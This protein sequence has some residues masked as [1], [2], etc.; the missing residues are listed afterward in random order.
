MKVNFVDLRK[1]YETIKLDV[2]RAILDAVARTDYIL[3]S[4]V[5]VFEQE[6]ASFCNSKHCVGVDSGTSALH[7]ALRA[8][9]I[10]RGDEVITTP[11]TFIATAFAISYSGARPVFVDC[12]EKSFNIDVSKIEQ[13][14]TSKTKA[15]I[16]VHLY[17]QPA[18]M[19]EISEIAE[20]HGLKIIEDACQ[21]HGA[22]YSGKRVPYT[23]IGCFSFYPGKNLGA[24]GDGGAVVTGSEELAET[25]RALRHYGSRVK[26]HHDFI[27]FNNRLD[28][29][30]AAVLRVKLKHLEKWNEARRKNAKLYTELLQGSGV[31]VPEELP[32]RK[33]VY[34]LYVIR[35]QK[36]QE[37][38]DF[39]GKTDIA[40]GIHY[41]VPI[42]LQKAYSEFGYSKG[43]FPISEKIS[44][45][46]LSLPMHPDLTEE[47]IIETSEVVR[48]VA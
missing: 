8:L 47:D 27:G 17:G 23:D 18:E 30:Q 46:I 14:I 34:H 40:S 10:G 4:E 3:G 7:L 12:D 31:A 33:H 35:T 45:E 26:Q 1:Q 20:K 16:P 19:K 39:L 42:H 13:T 32:N 29:V 25:L 11:N 2:D 36:R 24:Y 43:S 6:F 37:L 21:A 44:G 38:M 15:I 22:E 28:N 9:G 41:Q 5:K 48:K